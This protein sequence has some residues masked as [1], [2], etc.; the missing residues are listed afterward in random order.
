VRRNF[1]AAIILVLVVSIPISATIIDIP[2]DY[3]TIQQGINV[4]THGD[5][6]LV[7]PGTYVENISFNGHDVVVASLFLMTGDL[8]HIS[9]TII[10][11]GSSGTVV[12]FESGE[13][14]AAAITGFTITG[15]NGSFGGGISCAS[16]SSP[17]VTYN[18]ITDN[19]ASQ[20][21]GGISCWQDC[22]P[23]IAQ[24][25][26]YGNS[27]QSFGGGILCSTGCNPLIINNV[28]S[29]NS[30][31]SQGGGI[32]SWQSDPMISNSIFWNNEG[33]GNDDEISGTV[34]ITYSDIEGG[35]SG[36]GNI[37][38]DPLFIDPDNGDF[39][40]SSDSCGYIFDSPCIDTGDPD[41]YD[42]RHGCDWGLGYLR[43]DMGAYGGGDS[44]PVGIENDM[45]ELPQSF[46]IFRNYPNPFNSGTTVI[47]DIQDATNVRI[48]IYNLLGRRVTTLFDGN[49]PAGSHAISW[50][51]GDLPSGIYFARLEAGEQT[52]NIKMVLLK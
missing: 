44:A 12:L 17:S 32:M 45:D 52:G 43:S 40:I 5:T 31:S 21:G 14:G 51:A 15:G 33:P 18:V 20:G 35:W 41:I 8:S 27:S 30:T 42:N 50:Q 6:V 2:V 29:G 47:F 48:D 4:S 49:K 3:P 25:V 16:G 28:V 36:Q 23:F 26:I 38:E 22:D 24:N 1:I 10:E 11:G 7:Q 13:T 34:T 19:T 39:H 46:A 37:D 9:S